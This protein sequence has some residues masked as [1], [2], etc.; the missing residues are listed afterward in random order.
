MGNLKNINAIDVSENNLPGEVPTTI[1]DCQSLEYLNLQGNNFQG[2]MPS[3]L[4]SL[5]GLTHLDL[6][7][8][9]LSGK[10]P[11]DLENL[12]FLLYFNASFN[13][14]ESEVPTKGVF[15]NASAVSVV[16]NKKFCGGILQL[17]L[18]ECP[19]IKSKK[20]ISRPVKPNTH[21]HIRC[22]MPSPGGIVSGNMLQKK[23]REAVNRQLGPSSPLQSLI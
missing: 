2:V 8:N 11:R 3:S 12:H 17:K 23:I 13:N 16:G 21:H 9:S 7:H 1:G 15:Q 14:L 19:D 10:I 18:S 4:A 5:K 22:T 20:G 6:S